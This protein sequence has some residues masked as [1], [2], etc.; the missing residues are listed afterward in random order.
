MALILIYD[1]QGYIA[2]ISAAVSN[3]LANGWPS[4]FLKNYPFVL[5]GNYYHISAYFVNPANICTSGRSAVEYKQ[6]GVGTDLYIQNGTDPI[7]NYAIKI[8]HEQSDISS[9]QWT[10]GRCFPSM[11][12]N[13]WFNV[14]KDMNCDEFWPAFLLYNGGKLNAFGWAMYANIT[15]PR[16]EHPKKSTIFCMYKVKSQK[17]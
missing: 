13:Y 8:P 4:T 6:Q 3:S 7:T 14:R 16:I 9:T 15:S 5:S 2:G 1:V 17:Y 12:K 11:G 10:E